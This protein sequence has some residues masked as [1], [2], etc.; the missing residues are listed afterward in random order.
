MNTCILVIAHCSV[1]TALQLRIRGQEGLS[2]FNYAWSSITGKQQAVN[3][4]DIADHDINELHI[5]CYQMKPDDDI[6]F[7]SKTLNNQA[8]AAVILINHKNSYQ[9]DPHLLPESKKWEIPIIV[10]TSEVGQNLN[11]ILTKYGRDVQAKIEPFSIQTGIQARSV[12]Q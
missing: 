4:M 11:T 1:C 6:Q 12:G 5:Q 7:L 8:T 10:V 3:W 9:I 2:Y